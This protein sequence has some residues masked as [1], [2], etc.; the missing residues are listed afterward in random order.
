LSNCK[1]TLSQTRLSRVERNKNVFGAFAVRKPELF[2][3]KQILLIDDVLTTG[4]TA[5]EC[6]RILKKAGA[7]KV[8]LLALARAKL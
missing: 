7:Q 6:A 8:F 5:S 3:K 1:H 4:I 2:S